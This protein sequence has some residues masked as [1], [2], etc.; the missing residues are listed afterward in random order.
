[1]I[2]ACNHSNSK[3][4]RCI[5][6]KVE[7]IYLPE[8]V[9]IIISEWMGYGLLYEAMLDSVLVAKDRFLAKGGLVVPSHTKL[10]VAPFS[11]PEVIGMYRSSW[12][13]VYGFDM[14]VMLQ[15][16]FDDARVEDLPSSAK[17]LSSGFSFHDI[18][19]GT[20]T[21]PTSSFQ[22]EPLHITVT[23]D[24]QLTGFCI[25]FDV[26]FTTNPAESP[27]RDLEKDKYDLD[28]GKQ[29]HSFSTG[30]KTAITHWQQVQLI[31]DYGENPV[32]TVQG[33]DVIHGQIEYK[34]AEDN[35]REVDIEMEW[36]LGKEGATFVQKWHLC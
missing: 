28:T 18:N 13:N 7:H 16:A 10:F 30:P 14:G 6:G 29:A 1:M 20:A 12:K 2:E 25:W 21:R 17:L 4:Y 15:N 3:K 9:D 27:L 32:Q 24:A 23:E 36:R 19:V 26:I 35:D 34:I 5:H 8:K 22:G 11:D 31:I 33:G